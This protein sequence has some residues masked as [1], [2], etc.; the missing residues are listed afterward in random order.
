MGDLIEFP[1]GE[2]V[3]ERPEFG[4]CCGCGVRM[5]FPNHDAWPERC[6]NGCS[7]VMISSYKPP[8]FVSFWGH[9]WEHRE[10]S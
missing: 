9:G 4:Y 6:E 8:P 10:H 3:G 1:Q 2:P 5:L 7:P